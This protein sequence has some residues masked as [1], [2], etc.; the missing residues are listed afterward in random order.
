MILLSQS[1]L[2][3]FVNLYWPG[4]PSNGKPHLVCFDSVVIHSVLGRKEFPQR[5]F[6]FVREMHQHHGHTDIGVC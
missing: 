4:I 1:Q 5:R 3:F 6:A 2:R